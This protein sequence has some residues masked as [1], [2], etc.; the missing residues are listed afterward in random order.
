MERITKNFTLDEL[1]YSATALRLGIDNTPDEKQK[2]SLIRLAK[3]VLQPIRD[4]WRGAIVVTSGYRGEQVNRVVGGS[5]TSQ[6]CKGEAADIKVGDREKNKRLFNLIQKLV[7]TGQIEVGQ[8]IDEYNY[9][10]IHVSLPRP[11]ALNNMILH[12]K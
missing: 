6:H 11:N 9:S 12:L 7:N 2:E 4:A 1:I 8:L 10:W 3:E 5:K